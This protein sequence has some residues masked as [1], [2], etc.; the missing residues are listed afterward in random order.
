MITEARVFTDEWPPRQ[1]IHRHQPVTRL[2]NALAPA[3]HGDRADDVLLSGSSG[4]GKTALARHV[5]DKVADHAGVP[6]THIRTLGKRT[7]TILR[8]VIAAYPRGPEPAS[9]TPTDGLPRLL[10]ETVDDPYIVVCDEGDDLCHSEALDQLLDCPLLSVVVI[11][12]NPDRWLAACS[13]RVRGSIATQIELDRFSTTELADILSARAIQGLRDGVVDNEQLREIADETAGVA[14]RGIQSLY[15]AAQLAVEREHASI[16][17]ADVADCYERAR[18]MIRASNIQSVPLH[19]QIL[20]GIIHAW[21][22]LDG[23]TLHAYYDYLAERLYRGSPQ[24]PICRRSRRNKLAKLHEYDLIKFEG[25]EHDRRYGV[26]DDE[27]DPGVTFDPLTADEPAINV[28]GST[29]N[30]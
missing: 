7:G 1:L 2:H 26:V 30:D 12:H 22:P 17:D 28:S 23:A 19:H 29:S 15:A 11:V 14:R 13:D 20:Y 9:N 25:K 10:R 5:V 24:T 27:I 18:H 6:Q 4:V 8:E 21:G 3:V 16:R